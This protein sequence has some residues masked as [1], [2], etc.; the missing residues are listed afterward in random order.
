MSQK[1]DMNN[2]T[3]NRDMNNVTENRHEQCH[4]K[5][6]HD[7]S[8]PVFRT[9]LSAVYVDVSLICLTP[10]KHEIINAGAE[11]PIRQIHSS[12]T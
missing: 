3:E 9:H 1:T 11:R 12:S 10:Q 4:R 8:T 7:F 5:Q 6:R 2:V